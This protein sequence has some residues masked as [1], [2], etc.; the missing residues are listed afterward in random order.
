MTTRL[1]LFD[2]DGTLVLTGGAGKRAISRAFDELFG[3]ADAFAG[4]NLAG[5]TDRHLVERA[6]ERSGVPIT[7]E[8]LAQVRDRY[9]TRLAEAI[10]EP[11]QGTQAVLPGVSEL[12]D[13]LDSEPRL[14]T[15]L[16]TGNYEV[17]ARIK[18]EHFDLWRRFAWGAFG[19]DHGERNALA[20]AA[21]AEAARRGVPLQ[22]PHHAVVI[23]DTPFDVACARAAGARVIAVATG[24]HSV[25]EL[26]ACGADAVFEDLT[27]LDSLI[28]AI[29][30]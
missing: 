3:V 1:L 7:P 13:A 30:G 17:G 22:H 28:A 16:L 25:D 20:L 6:L 15:A 8:V 19:D 26:R 18:L 11:A 2:I 9:L 14:Q 29:D 4:V 27:D 5:R 23:G 24:G 12:L 21:V 10:H